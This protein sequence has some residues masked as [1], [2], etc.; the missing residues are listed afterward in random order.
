MNWNNILSNNMIP[1]IL[2]TKLESAL[3][4][5][6]ESQRRV[7]GGSINQAAKITLPGDRSCFLK[8]NTTAD[9]SMF[10][11]EEK[12][13]QLLDAA[14]TGLFIPGVLAT[15]ETE[16]GI[17]FLV[18]EFIKE[19]RAQNNSAEIFGQ[20]LAALHKNQ[21][22][23]FGLDHDNYIGR[24]PQ[25]NKKHQS[26]IDFFI[27]E[28]MKPQLKMATDS[29]KL[30][31]TTVSHFQSMYKQL[32]DIFPEEQASLLHGDLWGGNYFYDQNG[33]PTIYD[34]AVY[35]G[36]REI[37]LAFTHL[38]GGFSGAFYDAY[39]EAYPLQPNFNQRK[40]IYNLYPLLVHTNLFGSSYAQQVKGI[41]QQF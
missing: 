15:G 41:V 8:W 16:N 38:F 5:T 13:L 34:P 2:V 33:R 11:V 27:K 32:P 21:H 25:S 22:E 1:D 4:Q 20:E 39:N 17:G 36:H 18:Q 35:Y 10:F 26:W 30:G 3:D 6:I 28:R 14:D 31:T 24:L 12:G 23:Q 29:G 19:G 9:P 40:D 37:E 7:S